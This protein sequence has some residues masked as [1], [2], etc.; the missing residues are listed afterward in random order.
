MFGVRG[1]RVSP[2]GGE[3][4]DEDQATAALVFQ[5]SEGDL[6]VGDGV[7]DEFVGGEGDGVGEIGVDADPV[8]EAVPLENLRGTSVLEGAADL[9]AYANA[10]DQRRSA[11]LA[12]DASARLIRSALR[13]GKEN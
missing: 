3:A 11:A 5:G 1:R 12:P 2:V 6:A 7:G 13:S 4:V 8:V 10:F 9:S